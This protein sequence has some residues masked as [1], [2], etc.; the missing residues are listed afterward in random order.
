MVSTVVKYLIKKI[1]KFKQKTHKKQ[2][3]NNKFIE[4]KKKEKKMRKT[5]KSI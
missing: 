5:T 3:A 1:D 2:Q 4:Q